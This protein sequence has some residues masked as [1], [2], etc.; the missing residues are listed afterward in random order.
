MTKFLNLIDKDVNL[1]E[2]LENTE[3]SAC[4][5]ALDCH[6]KMEIEEIVLIM[7]TQL[8]SDHTL[9]ALKRILTT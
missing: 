1:I 2:L 3:T 8:T 9:L 7:Q 4:H 5:L 6:K